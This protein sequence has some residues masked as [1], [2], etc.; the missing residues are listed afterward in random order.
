M[1]SLKEKAAIVGIG[2]TEYSR[3]AGISVISL[4][5]QAAARAVEDAGLTI[6][7]IDGIIPRADLVTTDELL[8]NF[9]IKDLRYSVIIRMGGASATASLQSAA[10]AVASQALQAVYAREKTEIDPV[11]QEPPQLV[12]LYSR[13]GQDFQGDT[14]GRSSGFEPIAGFRVVILA[15]K[16]GFS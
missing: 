4:N 9:G 14:V 8:S 11:A 13:N 5:L 7:D 1:F 6:K 16:P 2:E 10:M 15:H 3:D 12:V